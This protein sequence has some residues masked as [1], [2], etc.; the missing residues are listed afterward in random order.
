MK[1]CEQTDDGDEFS[2]E[3]EESLCRPIQKE[4]FLVE[5][6]TS[7]KIKKSQYEIVVK[8]SETVTELGPELMAKE[9]LIEVQKSTEFNKAGISRIRKHVHQLDADMKRIQVELF[10]N[11]DEGLVQSTKILSPEGFSYLGKLT[12]FSSAEFRETRS[13]LSKP[14]K[15]KKIQLMTLVMAWKYYTQKIQDA[16]TPGSYMIDMLLDTAAREFEKFEELIGKHA[17]FT[18]FKSKVRQLKNPTARCRPARD[19]L[20][21]DRHHLISETLEYILL[22]RLCRGPQ[23]FWFL[24]HNLS[25]L[26]KMIKNAKYSQSTDHL[27][28]LRGRVDEIA[29]KYRLLLGEIIGLQQLPKFGK[30]SP[31]NLA[32]YWNQGCKVKIT[33]VTLRIAKEHSWLSAES[34][35][36]VSSDPRSDRSTRGSTLGDDEDSIGLVLPFDEIPTRTRSDS[37]S[38]EVD[39]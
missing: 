32:T 1:D 7:E 39:N 6:G 11:G 12:D 21:E 3:F 25:L 38:E 17:T 23:I 10:I 36:P 37:F 13:Q 33:S 14:E 26:D 5:S 2:H 16:P 20:L 18:E 4:V 8:P 28:L 19:K 35:P 31:D 24:V 27:K 15:G 9:V 30:S 34:S 29:K 22:F